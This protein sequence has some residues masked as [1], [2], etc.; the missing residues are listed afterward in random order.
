MIKKEE[1]TY[2]IE[3]DKFICL[4]ATISYPIYS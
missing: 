3:L 1:Q 2:A 4:K